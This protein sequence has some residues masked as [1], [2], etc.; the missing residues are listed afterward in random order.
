MPLCWTRCALLSSFHFR[1]LILLHPCNRDIPSPEA[2]AAAAAGASTECLLSASEAPVAAAAAA[3]AAL[4][5]AVSVLLS[6][7]I[8]QQQKQAQFLLCCQQQQQEHQQLDWKLQQQQRVV[9]PAAESSST[10]SSNSSSGYGSIRISKTQQTCSGLSVSCSLKMKLCKESVARVPAAFAR[11]LAVSE[12]PLMAQADHNKHP[13]APKKTKRIYTMVLPTSAATAGERPRGYHALRFVKLRHLSGRQLWQRYF[14]LLFLALLGLM[15]LLWEQ[16]TVPLLLHL[17]QLRYPSVVAVAA[18]GVDHE[19]CS[20]LKE[21]PQAYSNASLIPVDS[22]GRRELM[23]EALESER[24]VRSGIVS[25]ILGSS[26][27]SSPSPL[28]FLTRSQ[29]EGLLGFFEGLLIAFRLKGVR[30]ALGGPSLVGSLERHD[31]L[32]REASLSILFEEQAKNSPFG[33]ISLDTSKA[34]DELKFPALAVKLYWYKEVKEGQEGA[35]EAGEGPPLMEAPYVEMGAGALKFRVPMSEWAPF[36]E[37]PLGLL[38]V[39]TPRNPLYYLTKFYRTSNPSCAAALQ[40]DPVAV[41]A[42][43]SSS[44]SKGWFSLPASWASFS[45]FKC[46]SYAARVAS[47]ALPFVR[48]TQVTPDCLKEEFFR[49]KQ[50]QL[51]VGATAAGAAAAT[52]AGAATAAAAASA[53]AASAGVSMKGKTE[54]AVFEVETEDSRLGLSLPV[55]SFY[56]QTHTVLV[57]RNPSSSA[58]VGGLQGVLC[59]LEASVEVSSGFA[60]VSGSEQIST[61]AH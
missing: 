36:V 40:G 4:S 48:R 5:S 18:P 20:L 13:D 51:E 19:R 54:T 47:A 8:T 52:V 16:V 2:D 55:V 39:P 41:A 30:W 50:M 14:L 56:V 7:S 33:L 12:V 37:R 29:H 44:S 61:S 1:F 42:A 23:T 60:I 15:L 31:L 3:S 38:S 46:S 35:F 43:G 58:F 28:R 45:V 10:S 25:S 53:A 26:I 22:H 57:I 59:P 11:P 24:E 17:Q 32:P 34:A 6:S 21:R 27:A 9:A 49:D